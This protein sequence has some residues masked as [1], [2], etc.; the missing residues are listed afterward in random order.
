MQAL[1][2]TTRR[3][4][5]LVFAALPLLLLAPGP[6]RAPRNV[7][8]PVSSAAKPVPAIRA[9]DLIAPG[10]VIDRSAPKGWTHLV[11]KSQP[12]LP[13]KEKR[14]VGDTTGRLATLVFTA[15]A[16]AVEPYDAADGQRYRLARLGLGVGV[17]IDGKDVIVSPDTQA[18]LGANLGLLARQVI[19]AV[20]EKQKTVRLV[21][22]GPTVAVLDTP[23]FMP[24]GKGH[25]PVV[26]RYAFLVDPTSGR[27][28]TLVWRID[29]DGR[30][31][32][33]GATGMIEWLPPNKLIDAEL[34]VDPSEFTLGVPSERAF[35]VK[36]IPDGQRQFSIPDGLR[37]PAGLA[38]LTPQQAG[39]LTQGLRDMIRAAR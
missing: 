33:D 39:Q 24:R 18:R 36:R 25:A 3:T 16:A 15:T 13:D 22:V 2:K 30:G 19:S 17:N 35:A 32:Y 23:A 1:P 12:S 20:Y 8:T 11:L 7:P 34:Q 26:M 5:C 9:V 28:D 37:A 38:R 10:T 6:E 4:L 14:K 21:A 27:L 31:G 29:T